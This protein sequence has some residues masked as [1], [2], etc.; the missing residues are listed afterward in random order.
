MPRGR[1]TRRGRSGMPRRQQAVERSSDL[2]WYITGPLAIIAVGV[3]TVLALGS[4]RGSN[5]WPLALILFA[6]G[7]AAN[8]QLFRFVVGRQGFVAY[9]N[10]I[11]LVLALY[12]LRPHW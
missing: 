8:V 2:A 5:S 10:E 11:P 1:A 12:L 4:H 3:T 7:V 6:A 9:F